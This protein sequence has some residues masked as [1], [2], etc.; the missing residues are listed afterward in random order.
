M[1]KSMFIWY[2][3]KKDIG[4]CAEQIKKAGF[5]H[6]FLGWKRDDDSRFEQIR[7]CEKLGLEIE[8]AHTSFENINSMWLEGDDGKSLTDY[9]VKSIAE[10]EDCGIPVLIVHLS[11][12]FTPPAYNS[13]GLSRYQRICDEAEKRGV[14]IAFENLRRVDYLDYIMENLDS[15][16]KRFCFDIGHE[17]IYNDGNGVLEKYGNL[18]VSLHLHDNFGK[19]DNHI[20]PFDG[21]I[22]WYDFA[23]RFNR[24]K[25]DIP[26]T[27]EVMK[28]NSEPDYANKAFERACRIEEFILAT[29]TEK[30]NK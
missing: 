30:H 8:S 4:Y 28:T 18:L 5:T 20:L 15:S 27:L 2:D 14:L 13:L 29:K 11:S 10:A 3:E 17:N 21:N 26:I 9:F 19:E 23:L 6:T 1:K 12:T 24:Q 22:D 25:K 7:L 16:A